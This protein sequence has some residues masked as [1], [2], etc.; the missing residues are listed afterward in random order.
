MYEVEFSE[1]D[2]LI[3]WNYLPRQQLGS[4]AEWGGSV[5]QWGKKSSWAGKEEFLV[6]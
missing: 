3:I 5:L 2:S 1:D 4:L 6:G